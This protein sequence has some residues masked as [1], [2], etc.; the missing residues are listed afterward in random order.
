M[1]ATFDVRA[2]TYDV[3]VL[4][5]ASTQKLKI[6][7]DDGKTI[8]FKSDDKTIMAQKNPDGSITL[9]KEGGIPVVLERAP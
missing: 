4:G 1:T 2:G 3:I 7:S 6:I 5:E 8:F 9:S